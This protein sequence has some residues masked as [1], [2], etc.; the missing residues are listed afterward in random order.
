MNGL[1]IAIFN[2]IS[3]RKVKVSNAFCNAFKGGAFKF[4]LRTRS[5]TYKE[6]KGQQP[7]DK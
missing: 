5:Y 3:G 6:K 4:N 7:S 1:R 2:L